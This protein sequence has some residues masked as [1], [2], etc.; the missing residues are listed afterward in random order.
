MSDN[1][2][3][4]YRIGHLARVKEQLSAL[5]ERADE[6]GLRDRLLDTLTEIWHLLRSRPEEWGDPQYNT[7]LPGG[8]VYHGF[9]P[10]CSVFFAVYRAQRAVMVLDILPMPNGGLADG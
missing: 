7:H 5:V 4:R 9:G 6:R 8:K 10:L 3:S 2:P 1:G